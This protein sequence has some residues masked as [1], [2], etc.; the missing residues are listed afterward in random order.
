MRGGGGVLSFEVR[1]G[2][3]PARA[4][5]NALEFIPIAT[6][7]GGIETTT[8]IPY[9]L[10]FNEEELGEAAALTGI[11]PGLVRMSV[12]IEDV[13]DLEKDLQRALA[14]AGKHQAGHRKEREHVG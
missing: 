6:S 3:E 13:E 9:E 5:V 12:G 2:I 10:D 14:A 8:E 7:L 4:F 1:G 11:D